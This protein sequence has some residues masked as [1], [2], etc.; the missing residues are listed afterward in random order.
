M[1]ID[2]RTTTDH[3]SVLIPK[4]PLLTRY[5]SALL[6]IEWPLS[7]TIYFHDGCSAHGSSCPV[8]AWPT[9]LIW[10]ASPV[11]FV[12]LGFRRDASLCPSVRSQGFD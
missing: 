7:G 4:E 9:V 12:A 3:A 11:P 2:P 6:V 10:F 1:T 8:L 5:F